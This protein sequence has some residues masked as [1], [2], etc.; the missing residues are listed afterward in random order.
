MLKTSRYLHL[1]SLDGRVAAVSTLTGGVVFVPPEVAAPITRCSAR[2]LEEI[3]RRSPE[4]L[5]IGAFVPEDVDERDLIRVR[6]G[7]AR[8]GDRSLNLTVVPTLACNMRCTYCDQPESSRQHTMTEQTGA[9]VTEYVAARMEGCKLV[10]VTWYGGEPLLVFDLLG[11]MQRRLQDLCSEHQVAMACNITTNGTLLTRERAAA[12]RELGVRQAQ[13]TLDGPRAVHDR[14]RLG[15]DGTGTFD[16]ILARILDARDLLEIRIRV[17]VDRGNASSLPGLFDL[18]AAHGLE[19]SAYLAP[20]VGFDGSCGQAESPLC[21]GADYAE[22]LL[23]VS[24][25]L[26][27]QELSNRLT[28]ASLPCTA[29]SESTFVFGPRGHV[30]RCWHDLGHPERAIDHVVD[31]GGVPARRLFWL[32]YDPLSD[33]VCRDCSVLPLCLG[34]CPERRQLGV[35]PPA[36][37]S[38]LRTHLDQFVRKYAARA[39]AS[40]PGA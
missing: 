31:G 28:P 34:G 2:E 19:Q 26:S 21:G 36:C 5:A 20:V 29:P 1:V 32:T 23:A 40:A 33:P 27:T 11:A 24:D 39:A 37:C 9:A 8:F 12:L 7:Q 30:Y 25:A 13:V 10:S 38:P 4:L 22:S 3:A 35:S 14:R 17:N 6:M 18:L 16:T 15:V